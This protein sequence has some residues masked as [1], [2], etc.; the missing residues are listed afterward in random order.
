M[1]KLKLI[2]PVLIIQNRIAECLDAMFAKMK[3]EQSFLQ[4]HQIQKSC[5]LSQ[6][7]I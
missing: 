3:N 6:M 1:A 4:I 2:L 7:F 5:L